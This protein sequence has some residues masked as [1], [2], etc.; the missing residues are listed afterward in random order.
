M[1]GLSQVSSDDWREASQPRQRSR[2]V[3]AAV[4]RKWSVFCFP[5]ATGARHNKSPA[6]A[7]APGRTRE[8]I[9]VV[10]QSPQPEE[11][12]VARLV[13]YSGAVQ[14]VGFRVN[15]A[16]IARHR[17]VTGYIKNL[18]DGRVELYAEGTPRAVHDFLEAVRAYWRRNIHKE[19]IEE[20]TLTGAYQHFEIIH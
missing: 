10:D 13:R 3:A 8:A 11:I 18:P 16:D 17:P 6:G 14:G 4:R 9:T 12:P 2:D 1:A 19:Q 15:T 5:P 7:R 20:Q